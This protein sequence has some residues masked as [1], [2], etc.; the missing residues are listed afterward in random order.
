MPRQNFTDDLPRLPQRVRSMDGQDVDTSSPHLN[1]RSSSD[2]GGV[3][4]INLERLSNS[5][6]RPMLSHRACHL[7]K[8]YIVDRV[9]KRK[10]H[11]VE[12]DFHS[13]CRLDQWLSTTQFLKNL[14]P[15]SFQWSNFDETIARAFLDHGVRNTASKGN[16]FS[17]LRAFYRW[18]VAHQYRDFDLQIL[19]MLQ[20]IRAI[21]NSKGHHVR[22]HHPTRG[23]LSPDEKLLVLDACKRGKG[24]DQDRAIVMLHMELGVNPNSTARIKKT[25][26]KI[27][28]A[29]G[30][31]TYQLDIPRVKKRTTK[32]EVKRRNISTNLGALLQTLSKH[33]DDREERL[34]YWLDDTQPERSVMRA[35]RTFVRHSGLRS[36]R[37][38]KRLRLHPR[39]CRTTL[40]THM[41]EEGASKFHIAEVLDHTDLQNVGVYVETVSSIADAV[42]DATDHQMAPLVDRFL[43]RIVDS[44]DSLQRNQ[45]VPTQSPHISLPILNMGGVGG[46]GRDPQKEGLCDLFPPLS[47]YLCP[48]FAAL[49]SGPHREVLN[50]LESYVRKHEA[51]ADPRILRQLDDIILAIRT[52]LKK[53]GQDPDKAYSREG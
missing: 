12:N 15:E 35:M 21:G 31:A 9:G 17:R 47:C 23:P 22:F 43:G 38:G 32:R 20:S 49:Q 19:S 18:G 50:S 11:T 30:I 42:A 3:L 36:P 24:T 37:T 26:F 46:C 39:R 45:I 29:N 33:E 7:A 2:G 4:T 53:L 51:N 14:K 1:I 41:A 52:V 6:R 16:D 48:F 40:A 13:F 5:N 10:G 28:S 25:D 34:L 27:Y 8:L 44:L